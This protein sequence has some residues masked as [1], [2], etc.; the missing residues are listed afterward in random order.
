MLNQLLRKQHNMGRPG[1]EISSLE[2]YIRAAYPLVHVET[3]EEERVL[4]ELIRITNAKNMLLFSFDIAAGYRKFD[5][6]LGAFEDVFDEGTKIEDAG[7]AIPLFTETKAAGVLMLPDFHNLFNDPAALRLLRNSLALR[8]D[9][10]IKV[11]V[12]T[13]QVV[14]LPTDLRRQV[15]IVEY[16]LPKRE[17][18]SG[19]LADQK[20]SMDAQLYPAT[21]EEYDSV[22]EAGRGLTLL[23]F[24][25]IVAVNAI[26]GNQLQAKQMISGKRE[27]LRGSKSLEYIQNNLNLHDVG[28]LEGVLKWLELRKAAFTPEAREFGLPAPKGVLLVGHPGCGKSL[29][30]S[31]IGNAWNFPLIRFNMG[32][33]FS[34]WQGESEAEIREAWKMA[35]ATAPCILWVDEID[36]ALGGMGG[37]GDNG[38]GNRI[39]GDLL[40][41]MQDN[42]KGVVVVATCNDVSGLPSAILRK[43]RF[44]EIFFVD[45]PGEGTLAEILAIHLMRRG[46]PGPD[47][48]TPEEWSDTVQTLLGL[49][50]AE[51]EQAVIEAMYGAFNAGRDLL[52]EDIQTAA[53]AV[54]PYCVLKSE[55]VK[56]LQNWAESRAVPASLDVLD[57]QKALSYRKSLGLAFPTDTPISTAKN[58]RVKRA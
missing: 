31:V 7:A 28:G 38:T 21:Q 47:T 27:I 18:L 33:A 19:L 51:V 14:D 41:K 42:T 23:E 45:L 43:G 30:C 54:K 39:L 12:L 56:W 3:A 49:V 9:E 57:Y 29:V 48:Y 52:P 22:V 15:A 6:E 20:D 24:E 2:R 36:K 8:Y 34:K 50:G 1:K 32:A 10:D 37:D 53:K 11:L 13:S 26:A 16:A 25:N 17:D 4:E 40:T 5:R 44:D 35:E 55:E 58:P 46:Q